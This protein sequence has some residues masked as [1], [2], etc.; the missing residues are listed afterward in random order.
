MRRNK[1]YALL[2]AFTLLMTTA[3][4]AGSVYAAHRLHLSGSLR[5]LFQAPQTGGG[6]DAVSNGGFTISKDEQG[7]T[8]IAS[9]SNP[10][11]EAETVRANHE[12]L[13]EGG[14][15]SYLRYESSDCGEL[16]DALI[17]VLDFSSTT[18]EVFTENF[19]F[20]MESILLG[21]WDIGYTETVSVYNAE[22][23]IVESG[24]ETI[25]K[26]GWPGLGNYA[27]RII[28]PG[29]ACTQGRSVI[30]EEGCL[31]LS[32]ARP[33]A[34]ELDLSN[35][36]LEIVWGEQRVEGIEIAGQLTV[37]TLHHLHM[38]SDAESEPQLQAAMHTV[39]NHILS[40]N[41]S[42]LTCQN[43]LFIKNGGSP[44]AELY[45]SMQYQNTGRGASYTAE[46]FA[47]RG[48][49]EGGTS[50][51]RFCWFIDLFHG[52]DKLSSLTITHTL[53]PASGSYLTETLTVDTSSGDV[54]CGHANEGYLGN[55][56]ELTP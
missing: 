2:A 36:D 13:V 44:Y 4:A 51:L 7:R 11:D 20:Q 14:I 28:L 6:D 34:V 45:V 46:L 8:T 43:E 35:I 25:Q 15:L 41:E 53:R 27:L 32:S 16:E 19:V 26:D 47:P 17:V 52:A 23:E 18:I 10:W 40:H 56:K 3:L 55:Y 24:T 30:L 37:D 39:S 22:G 29:Y 1:L 9:G 31:T 50:A 48:A 49:A 54:T 42:Y 21:R 5:L 12:A 38:I 33:T